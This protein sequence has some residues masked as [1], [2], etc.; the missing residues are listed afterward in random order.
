M[1]TF[2]MEFDEIPACLKS[3]KPSVCRERDRIWYWDVEA[4]ISFDDEDWHISGIRLFADVKIEGNWVRHYGEDIEDYLV[5]EISD[6]LYGDSLH[7]HRIEHAVNE[8]RQSIRTTE[9]AIAYDFHNG[10]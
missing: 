10:E 8:H 1:N 9:Y 7:E 2:T 5:H 6:H 3:G 4:T